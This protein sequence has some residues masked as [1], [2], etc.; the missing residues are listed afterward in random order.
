M[1]TGRREGIEILN[2]V[3]V[4]QTVIGTEIVGA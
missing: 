2:E 1:M 3:G 4:I